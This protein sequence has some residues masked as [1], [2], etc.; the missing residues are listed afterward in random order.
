[1]TENK[2]AKYLKYAVGE[3]LLVMIG[4]LLAL[5]V[6]NWNEGR[7]VDQ[8]GLKLI[9]NLKSDFQRNLESVEEVIA[10]A[11]EVKEGLET[12]LKNAIGDNSSISVEELK[13]LGMNVLPNNLLEPS[14]GFYRAAISTGSIELL[15][16][17]Q[18]NNL[19]VDFEYDNNRLQDMDSIGFGSYFS[20]SGAY[21]DIRK[22]LGAVDVLWSPR[23][24]L[25]V[26]EAYQL[27]DD[28][29]RQFIAQKEVF[30][31]ID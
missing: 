15:E 25:Y 10:A 30:A 6:N 2:P 14:L 7:K 24:D 17:S 23:A 27:T 3:V 5:Q 4:I 28:E 26:P 29:Y 12:F 13:T 8:Q 1:M 22:Q 11:E 20:D 19:F 31:Y 18:L 21:M 16:G 9:E